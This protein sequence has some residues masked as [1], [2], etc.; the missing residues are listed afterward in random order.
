M[1]YE[2]NDMNNFNACT[3]VKP[4]VEN[5]IDLAVISWRNGQFTWF[6]PAVGHDK[7]CDINNVRPTSLEVLDTPNGV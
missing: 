4:T 7:F 6:D 2:I 5:G 3:E 1:V